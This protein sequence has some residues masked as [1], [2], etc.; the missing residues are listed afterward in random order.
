ML[1]GL[2]MVN[3]APEGHND[4]KTYDQA[5]ALGLDTVNDYKHISFPSY[6]PVKDVGLTAPGDSQFWGEDRIWTQD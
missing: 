3:F 1:A 5:E 6:G 4:W 2:I